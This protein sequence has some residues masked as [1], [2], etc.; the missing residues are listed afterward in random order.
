MIIYRIK[1][2]E[3]K[4]IYKYYDKDDNE[5]NDKKIL[6]YIASIPPV[7]PAY[8]QVRIYYEK[9]PKILFDGID[10]K[11]RLQQIYSPKWRKEADKEK[12]KALI[13]FGKKL[14]IM[15]LTMLKN[16]KSKGQS[17][18]KIISI[19]LRITTLCGFRVG[20]IKYQKLYGSVG[21]ITLDVSHLKFKKTKNGIELHI[22]FLGKKGMTNE[23]II[24]EPLLIDELIKLADGKKPK[25]YIFMYTDPETNTK[26]HITAIDINNW[27]KAYNENFTSKF[28]RN[29]SVNSK[30]IDLMRETHI[31]SLT[32]AQRK[33]HITN[34]IKE[35]SCSINNTPTICKKS[36]L[37]PDLVK[38]YIEHPRKYETTINKS[39]N[40]SILTYIKFLES[41]HSK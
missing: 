3:K 30:F 12:F 24:R 22:K 21:L 33:K 26:K 6:E 23:C 41:I 32:E 15:T 18:D 35:L 4:K 20:Q 36:Y 38:L 19:I 27:L 8:N 34:I 14:P 7:P 13:E 39:P 16:I 31:S 2:N 11:G 28:F 29:F 40:N 10:S 9:Q 17:K 25:D 1:L 37:D 5:I